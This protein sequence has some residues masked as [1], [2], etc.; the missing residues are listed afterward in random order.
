MG[1]TDFTGIIVNYADSALQFFTGTGIFYT[2]V[3]FGGQDGTA[4]SLPW[5][6]FATPPPDEANKLVSQQLVELIKEMQSNA[7]SQG[8]LAALWDMIDNAIQTM[9][10]PPSQYS[11]YANAIVGK[12]L[13]LV[14]AGWWMELAQAPLKA[15]H[16]LGPKPGQTG[17]NFPV[18]NPTE[19]DAMNAYQFKVKLGD[20]RMQRATSSPVLACS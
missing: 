18:P 13:A 17:K 3:H 10:F 4:S 9:P 2:S 12:P 6:P 20:V 8:Y 1:S 11:G 7:S 19:E 16:T 14:N 15:Q 5:A